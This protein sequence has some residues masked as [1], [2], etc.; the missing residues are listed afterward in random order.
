MADLRARAYSAVLRAMPASLVGHVLP[1]LV[2]QFREVGVTSTRDARRRLLIGPVNSAG[3]AFGWARAAERVPDVAAASMMFRGADDVFAF[4]A[5]HV[6]PAA[7]LVGNARW[8]SA[9][10]R[11]ITTGFTH[12]LIESAT[13]LHEPGGDLGELVGA[14]RDAGI[15]VGLVWHGSD[16]RSPSAHASRE[17]DSPFAHDYPDTAVLERIAARNRE[18]AAQLGA[19]TFVSTPDLLD[20]VPAA[21]W[22]P[23][24]VDPQ[25]WAAPVRIPRARPVVV[26]APSRAGLKGTDRIADALHRLHDEGVIEYREVRGVPSSRMPALYSEADIVLDQFLLGSYGVA[27][28]EAMAAGCAV[29]GHV[30]DDVRSIVESATGLRLPILQA[31]AEEI[32]DVLRGVSADPARLPAASTAGPAFVRSVHDGALSASVLRPFLDA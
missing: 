15:R 22:L 2:A 26:H 20:D 32:E 9:E 4:T 28:C 11:A 6:V 17:P 19:D 13:H 16:V 18:W 30:S 25:R 7:A 12:V 3:Q 21:S 1:G 27:A 24:V 23:V 5:D 31:R 10:R 14:L 29:I 8:R